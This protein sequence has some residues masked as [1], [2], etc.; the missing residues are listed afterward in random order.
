MKNKS[1]IS[2]LAILVLVL[3]VFAYL[4][5]TKSLVSKD[6]FDKQV[7]SVESVSNSDDV[8]EIEKDLDDTE[9]EDIDSEMMQ[10]EAELD[11]TLDVNIDNL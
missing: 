9:I 3:G 7:D 10:I 2:L 4:L 8:E 1:I 5:S 6:T 11:S